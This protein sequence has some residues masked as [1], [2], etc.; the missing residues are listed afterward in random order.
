MMFKSLSGLAAA[1][2]MIVSQSASAAPLYENPFLGSAAGGSCTPCSSE[3][4]AATSF[5]LAAGSTVEQIAAQLHDVSATADRY[6]DELTIEIFDA[7][8]TTSL[9]AQTLDRSDYV[10]DDSLGGSAG[11]SFPVVTFDVDDFFLDAGRYFVSI[12]GING[13]RLGWPSS[14]AAIAGSQRIQVNGSNLIGGNPI[15]GGYG[16]RIEGFEGKASVP[17]PAA[18]LLMGLI[19][20]GLGAVR[21]S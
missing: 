5:D 17:A 9:F 4:R 21:R 15:S 20:V 10:R 7:G 18:I 16:V 8:L 12:F 19:V 13:T 2:V 14:P 6:M 11:S 3:Y 1:A